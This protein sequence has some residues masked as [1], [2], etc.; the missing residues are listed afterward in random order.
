MGKVT[1]WQPLSIQ[2]RLAI[3][4]YLSCGGFIIVCCQR[5]GK[6][7]RKRARGRVLAAVALLLFCCGLLCVQAKAAAVDTDPLNYEPLVREGYQHFYI[8][9]YDGALV[10]FDKVAEAHPNDPMA[11]DYVLNATVF[12]ELYR[13]DLLDTT[14]YA[15]DGFLT[16][17]HPVPE[18]PQVRDRIF[19][20]SDRIVSLCDARLKANSNDVN[21]LYARGWARSL[22]AAYM[23]MVERAFNAGLRVALQARS[24]H[25]HVLEIDPNYVDAKMVVGIYEYVV[26]ALPFAFKIIVGF[27][28]IHGSK[29]TGMQLLRDSASRGVITQVESK[30]VI[31]LF[32]RRET[33]YQEAITIIRQLKEQ[34]PRS[35]LICLEEAN[36]LKDVGNGTA[37]ITAYRGVL[38]QARKPGYFPSP[39]LD[40]AWFG[41]ADSLHGQ[42]LYGEAAAAYEQAAWAPGAGAELKRRSLVA[43]GQCFDL[44]HERDRALVSYH[45][46]ID[47]GPE[48]TQADLARGYIRSPYK[49]H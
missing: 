8:L 48:S 46:A 28:G 5:R 21:A 24:D 11:L 12:R 43:A 44:N 35:F 26:G 38:E 10:R 6:D 15:N 32:L 49:G 30:T 36:L 19:T 13:L 17:K 20:L 18:D 40:L 7:G 14:F 2:G 23:A 47:A 25:Q 37:A 16:G 31:A 41:L 39:H 9:D 42:R 27:A 34:Y 4:L 33:K 45:A 1:I 3:R 22:R 29:S